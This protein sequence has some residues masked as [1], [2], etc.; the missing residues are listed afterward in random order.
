MT[1]RDDHS[2]RNVPHLSP[3]GGLG[4]LLRAVADGEA[5]PEQVASLERAT[6][7]LS[8]KDRAAIES[9][10]RAERS[11]R[12]A[13]A[14]CMCA[15]CPP[16]PDALRARVLAA[17]GQTRDDDA[18]P[19][20]AP[21]PTRREGRD[22]SDAGGPFVFRLFQRNWAFAAA[23]IIVL[24]TVVGFL[25]LPTL[26]PNRGVWPPDESS[27]ARL[28]SFLGQ[29]H[30]HCAPLGRYA[31]LK[32]SIREAERA[33][34]FIER[35]TPDAERVLAAAGPSYRFLGV[36]PCAVPGAGDSMHM[37]FAPTDALHAPISV[38]LQDASGREPQAL[39]RTLA[40]LGETADGQS[41]R[42]FRHGDCLVYVVSPTEDDAKRIAKNLGD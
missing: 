31:D 41:V 6:A 17:A 42:A 10:I 39:P 33:E 40:Q 36:G 24:A 18:A 37:V 25:V 2:M 3:S 7:N 4:G 30:D 19:S 38:F 20:S 16:C 1:S 32:L 27:R 28:V 22:G 12:E 23:A 5:S 21:T 26:A 15:S 29:E 9:T 35:W 34:A 14:R 13:T 8:S 11:L